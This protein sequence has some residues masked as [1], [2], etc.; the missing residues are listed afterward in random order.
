MSA[1]ETTVAPTD[2][3]AFV[4]ALIANGIWVNVSGL[5]RYFLLVMPMLQAAYPGNPDVAPVTLPIFA[6]WG[7]WTVL[8]VLISTGFYW[9]Y[10][11]RSG[12]SSKD[13]LAGAA[14]FTVAT[15][16]L[17]WLGI[18]NMGLAPVSLLVAATAWATVEQII[19][20]FIV[21]RFASHARSGVGE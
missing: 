16:G 7:L 17:T 13:A 19:S 6:S 18:V 2:R 8:F 5:P 9:M 20:A 15:I 4:K 12:A 1:A 21:R 14:W 11:E 10:F 3:A